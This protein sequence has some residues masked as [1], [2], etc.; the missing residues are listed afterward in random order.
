[1]IDPRTVRAL[2]SLFESLTALHQEMVI[3]IAQERTSLERFSIEQIQEATAARERIALSITEST[4]RLADLRKEFPDGEGCRLSQLIRQHAA[5]EQQTVLLP[6]LKKLA[7]AA[8]A[9][10]RAQGELAQVL[11]HSNTMVGGLIS[12]LLS[13]NRHVTRGYSRKGQIKESSHPVNSSSA[14]KRA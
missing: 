7:E 8:R 3:A 6:R 11:D 4:A 5:L 12:I 14:L 10:H 2:A 1:M 9:S 13:G